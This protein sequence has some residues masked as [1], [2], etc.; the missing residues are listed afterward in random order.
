[1]SDGG[2][3][4]K[5]NVHPV[6][7][8]VKTWYN[9]YTRSYRSGDPH[10]EDAVNLKYDHTMRVVKETSDLC[11]SLRLSTDATA[12]AEIAALLHDVAR[13]EQ[14]RI[15]G[16]FADKKSVNHADFAM[17]IISR[18]RL[19]DG[20]CSEDA[21]TVITAI[22]YHNAIAVPEWI[23]ERQKLFCRLLR[24][25][26]K[27]D[28][29]KIVLDHYVNP[30]PGRSETVE[31]GIPEGVDVSPEV[32]ALIM[33]GETV[34]FD[35]IRSINDFKLIQLGWVFDLNFPHSFKCVKHRGYIS[36]IVRLLPDNPDVRRVAEKVENYLEQQC[37]DS[38][39]TT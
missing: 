7:D 34:P 9:D 32:C 1:M 4:R 25:A 28:I 19:T 11:A 20:L 23:N 39:G 21:D 13:F 35:L 30:D 26:D 31:V 36:S 37:A 18:N 33:A 14:F 2:E 22:K 17:M 16:T 5:S 6:F 15:F 12:L 8:S 27:L 3:I 10:L 24:D 38:A 29:Y